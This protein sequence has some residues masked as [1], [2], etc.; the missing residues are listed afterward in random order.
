MLIDDLVRRL[1]R[2][3]NI[4][5]DRIVGTAT[6]ALTIEQQNLKLPALF[7]APDNESAS[8]PAG[9]PD[10]VDE[11]VIIRRYTLAAIY[12]PSQS[13]RDV[14]PLLF[15]EHVRNELIGNLVNWRPNNNFGATHYL[16]MRV[17]KADLARAVIAYQFG[18]IEHINELCDNSDWEDIPGA[19]DRGIVKQ[20]P[21]ISPADAPTSAWSRRRSGLIVIRNP[22]TP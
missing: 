17:E 1:R 16:G 6:Y 13:A 9:L 12:D 3:D 15:T 5:D 10:N 11:Q 19:E 2:L 20:S 4:F 8:T 21:R 18:F 7:V 14:P 22:M